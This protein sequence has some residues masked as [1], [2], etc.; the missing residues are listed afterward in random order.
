MDGPHQPIFLAVI[1]KKEI[2]WHV[3]AIFLFTWM[4]GVSFPLVSFIAF[5]VYHRYI[6]NTQLLLVNSGFSSKKS[7]YVGHKET[8]AYGEWDSYYI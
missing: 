3:K 1:D 4:D 7:M 5:F 2:S 8:S 6:S